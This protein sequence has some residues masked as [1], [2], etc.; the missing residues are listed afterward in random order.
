M[1]A[2]EP[3]SLVMADFG[4]S[5]SGDG[6][7]SNGGTGWDGT[8]AE[9]DRDDSG[10][11]TFTD[12]DVDGSGSGDG[13][14]PKT[15]FDNNKKKTGKHLG[16]LIDSRAGSEADTATDPSGCSDHFQPAT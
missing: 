11:S 2:P 12:V 13:H 9:S 8:D 5:G 16:A 10:R 3:D 1:A 4:S 6:S 15:D 7:N 14:A